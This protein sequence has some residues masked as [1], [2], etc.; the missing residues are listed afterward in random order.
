MRHP[1]VNGV[2][3]N[4]KKSGI[5]I[6]FFMGSE[7]DLISGTGSRSDKIARPVSSSAETY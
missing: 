1:T 7:F 5:L 3:F 4:H 6:H 2:A